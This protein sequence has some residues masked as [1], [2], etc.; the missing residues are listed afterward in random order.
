MK[1]EELE[2][3]LEQEAA[4]QGRAW[5][6]QLIGGAWEVRPKQALPAL[7]MVVDDLVASGL[8]SLAPLGYPLPTTTE[9]S[10]SYPVST[11]CR[12]TCTA[13]FAPSGR[14]SMAS[15]LAL[16]T[17]AS[18]RAG[19]THRLRR[20][21]QASHELPR[22]Q[23]ARSAASRPPPPSVSLFRRRTCRQLAAL[24]CVSPREG[25]TASLWPSW[26]FTLPAFR[27]AQVCLGYPLP[28][29]E[30]ADTEAGA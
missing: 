13:P 16:T 15:A 1:R 30:E 7:Q 8:V 9:P 22:R 25:S 2:D 20:K 26:L 12:H 10:C 3:F 6:G 11:H 17:M 5:L 21:W 29:A 4:R 27:A 24:R 14:S 23:Q 28:G 19:A 18:A